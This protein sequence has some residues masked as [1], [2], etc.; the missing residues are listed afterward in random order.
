MLERKEYCTNWMVDIYVND[1]DALAQYLKDNGV[2]TRPMYPA[3]HSCGAYNQTS[4]E[5]TNSKSISNMGLWLPSS[6]SLTKDEIC[7]IVQ[8]IKEYYKN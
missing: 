4:T 6:F 1:R 8:K 5:L 7:G 3:I 2:G